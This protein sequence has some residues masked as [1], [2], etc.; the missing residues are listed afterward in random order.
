MDSY[1]HIYVPFLLRFGETVF[2][3]HPAPMRPR[4]AYKSSLS[5]SPYWNASTRS[6]ARARSLIAL[7]AGQYDDFQTLY[8]VHLQVCVQNFL[9]FFIHRF[10]EK[11]FKNPRPSSL[12]L[13]VLASS[14]QIVRSK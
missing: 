2:Y 11:L 9:T 4:T 8:K 5:N 3:P 7:I 6:S 1:G 14:I 10:L 12:F 13:E